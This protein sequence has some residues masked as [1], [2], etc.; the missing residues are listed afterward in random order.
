MVAELDWQDDAA[1]AI[2][3]FVGQNDSGSSHITN[4][5]GSS[6]AVGSLQKT[7][8]S[9]RPQRRLGL[10]LGLGLRLGLGLSDHSGHNAM[11]QQSQLEPRLGILGSRTL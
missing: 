8:G 2:S 6:L 10:G 11:H 1:V 5:L 7:L 4:K 3:R 9:Q